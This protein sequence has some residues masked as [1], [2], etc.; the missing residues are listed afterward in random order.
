MNRAYIEIEL[1][2][3][4]LEKYHEY[5]ALELDRAKNDLDKIRHVL[6]ISNN[7][8]KINIDIIRKLKIYVGN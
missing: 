3:I 8:A 2:K 6:D 7:Y 1:P 5:D 4:N